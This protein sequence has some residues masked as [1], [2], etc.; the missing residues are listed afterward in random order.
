MAWAIL[1]ATVSPPIHAAEPPPAERL[2]KIDADWTVH[3]KSGDKTRTVPAADLATWGRY[4]DVESGPQILLTDGGL[5]RADVLRIDDKSLVLGDATGLG[6]GLW[7]D[8]SLPKSRRAGRP[9]PAP[10]RRPSCDKLRDELLKPAGSE[11]RLLLA[12]GESIGGLLVAAPLDGLFLPADSKPEQQVF[13]ISPRGANEPLAIPAGKVIALTLAGNAPPAP[14]RPSAWM[15][16]DDGTLV[17]ASAIETQAGIVTVR[18]AAG[19]ELKTTL[20]GRDDPNQT[21]WDEIT[22]VQPFSPQVAWLSDLAPLGYKHIPF[23]AVEWPYAADHSVSGGRLRSGG[24]LFRKGLG[25][26]TTSRLAYDVS[27]YKTF[28]AEISPR[29]FGGPGRQRRLQSAARNRA[30]PVV[31]DLRKPHDSRRRRPRADLPRPER[32]S[33]PGVDRRVCRPR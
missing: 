14:A 16:L 4:R 31:A 6:R 10:C 19:G 9:V 32:R 17:N 30:E 21:F 26:H 28:A 5:I 23:L 25:M 15:G 2:L 18:L 33:P 27:G 22:L 7:D 12:G 20:A 29:R 1:V 8:S 24:A 11:D 3:L 13:R